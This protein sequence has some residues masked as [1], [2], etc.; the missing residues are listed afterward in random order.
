MNENVWKK[1]F[2]DIFVVSIQ[3]TRDLMWGISKMLTDAVG[4]SGSDATWKFTATRKT[5]RNSMV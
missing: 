4:V 5:G 3:C 1:N 2:I